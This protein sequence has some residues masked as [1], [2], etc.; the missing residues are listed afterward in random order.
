MVAEK[1]RNDL[2]YRLNVV[3]ITLPPLR[4]RA[5]DIP[6]LVNFRA[7]VH[8]ADAETHRENPV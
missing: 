7:E 2:F 5:E 4:E 6:L 3:P 1:F 8:T